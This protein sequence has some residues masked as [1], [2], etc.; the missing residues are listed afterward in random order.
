MSSNV[1]VKPG[2]PWPLGATYDGEGTNFA[3]F[4]QHATLMSLSLFDDENREHIIINLPERE[5][6]VWHGYIPGVQPGQKYGYRAHGPYR[7][8]EGHRFNPHKLLLDP[9]ARQI[10]GEISWDP[11]LF[12]YDTSA[13][14]GDL[15]YDTK[16]SARF[17]PRCV[18]TD[19]AFDWGD[20]VFPAVPNEDTILY[21]AH[22]RG[23]TM[24]REDIPE[25]GTF[26]ALAS[27]QMID[28]FV[29]LGIT[30]VQLMP[31]HAF[32]QD[33]FLVSKGLANYWGYQ[34]IGFFAPEPRY[35]SSGQIAEAQGAVKRLHAA[36]IE[37]ILD[38]VYNHTAEGNQMGPTLS[39][40]GL[41][42]FSYYRLAE[43]PRYY[44]NDSGTGNS[45]NIAHPMVMRLVMDSLRY[46]RQ[47]YHVDGFR[48]D[49]GASMGRTETGFDRNAPFFQ[50]VRQDPVLA[51]A[52]FYCE[53]WDV[54]PGGYQL[55]AF[56][57]PWG[58]HN[59]KFRD[60][61]RRFW[62]GDADH[63]RKLATRVSGS[64]VRF[65]HDNR[66]AWS[67]VN[68]V[69]CHDGFTLMDVVSYGHKHNEA[70]GED[71]ADG[72]SDNASDNL[73][74]EGPTDDRKITEARA[75]R[76]RNLM[77][78]VLL[79][80][81]T[82]FILGGDELGNSQGG[83]NNAYC[84]DN[85][86]GWIDWSGVDDPFHDFV[87]QMI[88]FRKDHPILR[89][90]RWL[91]ARERLIDGV[92]DL[93]WRNPDGTQMTDEDWAATDRDA[94][95]AEMRTASGT[96]EYAALETAVMLVFNRGKAFQFTLPK[97]PEGMVWVRHLDTADPT[98]PLLPVRKPL[99]VHRTSVV[100]LAQEEDR[101]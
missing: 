94:L 20:D 31:V 42:N 6:H 60:Q 15:S 98:A 40:R 64:A 51:G 63:V 25:R 77:A 62:R 24:Q 21:E 55:G 45:L 26:A 49:L 89:Q 56:P 68:M 16:D 90:K 48:F 99:L 81:G 67:S 78:T 8:D 73:G 44:L 52:K 11:A 47:V 1:A 79:S 59:D 29:Q 13:R 75:Q 57:S 9:Y 36:G 100:A 66:P 58:E 88:R 54:G 4:S 3:V 61:N 12:G 7:P 71:N 65:D 69:T 84:Q 91:H 35:L 76:R 19:P 34:T 72:H 37:V 101:G 33:E 17:M 82:P 28:H 86:I 93:F 46:W 38:V 30:A 23:L 32:V 50:A 83:N 10:S 92:P 14:S 41:D 97:A 70:N 27:D 5:G 43:S 85:E 96:P 53:P 95:I 18:V 39:F 2:R 74:T 80:Q 22:V 87:R